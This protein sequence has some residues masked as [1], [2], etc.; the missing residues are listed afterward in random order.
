MMNAYNHSFVRGASDELL[1]QS[2]LFK[3]GSVISAEPDTAIEIIDGVL[4]LSVSNFN[5][6][7]TI[8]NIYVS[9]DIVKLRCF[10]QHFNEY[11]FELV[12]VSDCIARVI[13]RRSMIDSEAWETM[14]RR[15]LVTNYDILTKRIELLSKSRASERIGYALGNYFVRNFSATE[16]HLVPRAISQRLMAKFCN[17][18]RGVVNKQINAWINMDYI[19]KRDFH[20]AIKDSQK[21][22]QLVSEHD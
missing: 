10:L 12:C 15:V 11:A 16:A 19:E 13:N 3:K 4:L 21:I 18:T 5:G 1:I 9:G 6:I 8:I 7:E 14:S 20:Y 17:T 22:A 2:R